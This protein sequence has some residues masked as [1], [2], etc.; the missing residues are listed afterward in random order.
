MIFVHHFGF[1]N[2]IVTSF[3]DCAVNWFMMMSGFVLCAAHEKHLAVLYSSGV[4]T[5]TAADVKSFMAKRV[6][7]V[8]PLYIV[9][10][11]LMVILRHNDFN[12][13]TFLPS[14]LM[15]QSWIPL[16]RYFFA[17]N[18][19][20]WFISDIMFCYLMFLPLLWYISAKKRGALKL[21]A[22]T[23]GTYCAMLMLVPSLPQWVFYLFYIFPPMQLAAFI[24]GMLLWQI[25]S[26]LRL[27]LTPPCLSNLLII[28]ALSSVGIS[29]T[30]YGLLPD[31]LNL[32]IYW[33]PSTLL[34]LLGLTVT[35]ATD[36]FMTRL[37][38]WRPFIMLGN[39]SMAFYLL[40]LSWIKGTRLLLKLTDVSL[41]A[42][43]ELPVSILL[44]AVLSCLIH[45][46]VAKS[47]SRG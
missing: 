5:P 13:M 33:W 27:S 37:L 23:M 15:I 38:H 45:S 26:R 21:F 2:R 24:M 42:Y 36:C 47:K 17:Y 8:A 6:R 34:M 10:L 18:S 35:D 32:G 39:A 19:P 31:R 12:V 41:P 4:L 29:M 3:G 14:L 30:G 9:A 25:A 22:L 44:L 43:V 20:A 7:H 11:V 16:D 40:H 46:R 28:I 1:D